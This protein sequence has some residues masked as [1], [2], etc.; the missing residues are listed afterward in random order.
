MWRP[1][2]RRAVATLGALALMWASPVSGSDPPRPK[3]VLLLH[4]YGTDFP[5][6]ARFDPAFAEVINAAASGSFDLFTEA[7]EAY[8]FREPDHEQRF[9]DYLQTKYAGRVDVVVAVVDPALAFL[10]RHRDRM[11]PGAPV[12]AFLTGTPPAPGTSVAAA[13]VW[14][15][16]RLGENLDL[17]LA[18]HPSARHVVVVEGAVENTGNTEREVRRRFE[19]LAS[20]ASLEYL[21]DLPLAEVLA[22]VRALTADSI[23]LFLRQVV[24]RPAEPIGYIS[25]F[26]QVVAVSP[27]PVYGIGEGLVGEG[28]VGG[29]VFDHAAIGTT[30]ASMAIRIAQGAPAAGMPWAEAAAVP[31]FDWRE[32]R[33]WSIDERR[34]PAGNRVLFRQS[35][36]WD[37]KGALTAGLMFVAV[38]TAI[39]AA[40]VIQRRRR[41]TAEAVIEQNY[42]RIRDL[43]GHLMTAQE[44]ERTRIARDLHDDAAQQAAALSIGLGLLK[45]K[46]NGDPGAVAADV[47]RLQS[48]AVDLGE[49][50][51]RFSHDLHPGILQRVGLVAALEAHC[52]EFREQHGVRVGFEGPMTLDG[53]SRD[54]S[55][56]LYRVAQ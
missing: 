5:F 25:G 54:A 15:G 7:L 8:R 44:A 30:L 52:E 4:Y 38:E 36:I 3:G 39:I 40:L 10:E 56:C 18:L 55:L 34:L 12:L 13:G 53:V 2:G 31:T 47:D 27:V 11:F 9:V 50:L 46:L 21:K 29:I 22:R 42:E 24:G 19:P 49:E 16:S 20:R 33:R 51:R 1:D 17:I 45:R 32:L 37:Y 35:S 48:R 43:A 14:E 6:R 23:V 26:K 41:R 28:L